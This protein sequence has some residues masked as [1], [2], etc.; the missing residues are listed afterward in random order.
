[1]LCASYLPTGW[2]SGPAPVEWVEVAR[3][4]SLP[5]KPAGREIAHFDNGS[6]EQ[7]A[8]FIACYL[9]PPGEQRRIEML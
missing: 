4:N 3:S 5:V 7:A 9:L 8:T 2:L 6:S 1:V